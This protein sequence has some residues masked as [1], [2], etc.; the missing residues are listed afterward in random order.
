MNFRIVSKPGPAAMAGKSVYS[1]KKA[2]E[3]LKSDPAVEAEDVD[4]GK[5]Y[6]A[7]ELEKLVTEGQND[8]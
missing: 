3:F 4:T 2:L 6:S 8:A 1:A 7:A 5:R